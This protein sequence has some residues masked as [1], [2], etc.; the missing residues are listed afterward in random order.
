[1]TIKTNEHVIKNLFDGEYFDRTRR[2][3]RD[4]FHSH[5]K[6]NFKKWSYDLCL[7]SEVYIT[8]ELCPRILT[9][10]EP[11]V[12]IKPGDFALLITLERLKLTPDVMAFI[13]IRFRYKKQGLI[14]IS[15]FHVDPNYSGRI[16][17]SV[18]NAGPHDIILKYTDPV[19]MIFF[20][21]IE[22]TRVEIEVREG[23]DC[24]PTEMISEIKGQSVT[25]AKNHQKIEKLEH[26]V[27]LYGGIGVAI[28]AALIG[29]ILTR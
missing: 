16:I 25:L 7:G 29:I 2:G 23:Y 24:I 17:F 4:D 19:F 28:I 20:H 22:E 18:Y 10:D 14:N 1:M 21:E 3:G 26:A 6:R 27:R 12:T 5:F 13:S 8:S 11:Y 9:E 15:G